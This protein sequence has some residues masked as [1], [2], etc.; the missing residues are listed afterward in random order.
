MPIT[1]GRLWPTWVRYL[2]LAVGLAA[3]AA[4][5]YLTAL[6]STLAAVIVGAAPLLAGDSTPQQPW[7][8]PVAVGA[9]LVVFALGVRRS[10]RAFRRHRRQ[11][12]QV[13]DARPAAP[14]A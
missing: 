12:D 7:V 6:V 10:V 4:A 5:G 2:V 8:T 9:G 13:S 14:A 1:P 3:S 11:D